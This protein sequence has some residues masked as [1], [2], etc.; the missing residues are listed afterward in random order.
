MTRERLTIMEIRRYVTNAL[1]RQDEIEAESDK[2]GL[3]QSKKFAAQLGSAQAYLE[4]LDDVLNIYF[5]EDEK[6][7]AAY[8]KSVLGEEV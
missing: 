3:E 4:M 8:E 1:S 5:E 6:E 7:E 2:E